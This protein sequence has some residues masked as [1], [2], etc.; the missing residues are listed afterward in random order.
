M[1]G[2]PYYWTKLE[3]S[4]SMGQNINDLFFQRRGELHNEFNF[5]YAS[6]FKS[7]EKYVKVVE[8]LSGKKSGLTR[9]EII[10]KENWIAVVS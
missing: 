5:I 1:G 3:P 4:K 10:K 7:P 9:D 6:M 8:T 2:V